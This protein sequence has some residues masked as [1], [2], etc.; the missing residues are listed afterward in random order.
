M[1]MDVVFTGI[2][3]NDPQTRNF[4]NGSV[5]TF[6]VAVSQG[7]Y[8]KTTRAWVDQGTMWVEVRP[9][10]RMAETQLA[11]VRKG[12]SVVVQGSLKQR[13]YTGNDGSPRTALNVAARTIGVMQRPQKQD[14]G[15]YQAGFAQPEPGYAPPAAPGG[16]APQAE[17]DPWADGDEFENP[18]F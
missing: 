17:Q 1:S 10:G 13:E 11:Q 3:G 16:Y 5:T 8:D 4:Q 7:Y 2:A 9:F 12:V 14:Q 6:S 18:E 15:G